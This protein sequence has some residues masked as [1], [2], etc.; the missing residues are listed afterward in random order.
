MLISNIQKSVCCALNFSQIFI[1]IFLLSLINSIPSSVNAASNIEK[2]SLQLPW[3]YQFEF[4]GYIAAKEMG[5][6]KEARLEVELIELSD[7][8]H[9]VISDVLSGKT[10]Y[11]V[12]DND[13]IQTTVYSKQPI[14]LLANYFK[15][16]ALVLI[17]NEPVFNPDKLVDKKIMATRVQIDSGAINLLLK[18]LKIAPESLNIIPHSFNINDFINGKVDIST[19]YLSN[20]IYELQRRNIPFSIID[21]NMYG[22]YSYNNNLFTS[23]DTAKKHYSRSQRLIDA[24]NKGWQY[25]LEHPEEI[26]QIIYNKY[27]QHKSIDALY[28]EAKTIKSLILSSF[29]PL[30]S[31]DK[32]QI[33]KNIEMI[34]SYGFIDRDYSLAGLFFD[35]YKPTQLTLTS[36]EKAFLKQHPSLTFSN[37]LDWFPYDFTHNGEKNG[38]AMG[39][40]IDYLRLL[41]DKIGVQLNFHTDDWHLL[42]KQIKKQKIDALH[43]VTKTSERESFLSFTKPFLNIQYSLVTLNNLENPIKSLDDLE[44]K[45]LALGKNWSITSHIRNNYPEIKILEVNNSKQMIEAV[46]FGQA[47]A[48]IDDY[49]TASYLARTLFISNIIISPINKSLNKDTRLRIAFRNEFEPL[50]NIFEKAMDSVSIYE[51]QRLKKKWFKV[52]EKSSSSNNAMIQFNAQELA[53]LQKKSQINVCI[54]PDWMPLEKFEQGKHIGMTADYFKIFNQKI[55]AP[56]N[57]IQTSS[58]TE[59]IERAKSRECDLFS[60]A[61]VTEERQTYMNFT[62]PYLTIPLVIATNS[63][64]MF[65]ADISLITDKK[66]GIVKGYAFAEILRK[67]Y[68]EMKII[69]VNSLN[70][71]LDM[72]N[73]GEL[74]GLIDTLATIGFAIQN[75]F[76][77]ELKI[78]GKFDENWELGI[79]TRNDEPLLNTIFNKAISSITPQEHQKI[80]NHW[81][82]VRF[83]KGTDYQLLLK[84][85]LL[86]IFIASLILYRNY[87]LQIYNKKLQKMAQTDKLTQL[88]NRLK[89]DQDLDRQKALSNR[90]NYTFSVIIIDIDFFKEINDSYG[91]LT[92]DSVLIEFALLLKNNIR[93]VDIAGRWGGEEFLIICPNSSKSSVKKL[94]EK[95]RLIIEKNTFKNV[96]IKITASFGAAQ[97]NQKDNSIQTLVNLADKALYKAKSNGRNQVVCSDSL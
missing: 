13:I 75:N 37:E 12:Y 51:L 57:I 97:Y 16:S 49:Q 6:Y 48:S 62:E 23:Q 81:V 17:S 72:V 8:R 3:K 54:D 28:F 69:D 38:A 24:T 71:G 65:I 95:L 94:A 63:D 19:A 14:V 88:Y 76:T 9:D 78:A 83:E 68:P 96:N 56:I 33:A 21:P 22:I 39:Y 64:E 87:T 27:S 11:G 79:A 29:Y 70:D 55:P 84:W 89:I 26:A 25:A 44:G 40:S 41:A 91:H 53:Y 58:W 60:L 36:E 86:V 4:A 42:I 66:I 47:D 45:I 59:S 52:Q 35:E 46:A 93:K 7:S 74:F 77:G 18:K 67:R 61:M 85:V 82:S 30:G 31:Y 2:I 1:L 15:R 43:L 32:T 20:E 92:G 73:N 5:F 34:N 90:Y 50:V 10:D 80:L